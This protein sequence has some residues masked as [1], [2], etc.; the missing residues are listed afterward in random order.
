MVTGAMAV[1]RQGRKSNF[2]NKPW[3]A[4]L[5]ARKPVTVAAVALANKN[6]RTAWVLLARGET[7]RRPKI[8]AA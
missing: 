2:A 7:Y 6:A 4:E 8:N 1:I 3:L 5:M